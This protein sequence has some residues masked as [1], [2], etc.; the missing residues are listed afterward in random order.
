MRNVLTLPNGST[1]KLEIPS[2]AT[3]T[4]RPNRFHQV[5]YVTAA[6]DGRPV[7]Y[8]LTLDSGAAPQPVLWFEVHLPTPD[9]ASTRRA[10]RVL[11]AAI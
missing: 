10:E 1:R 9:E 3:L 4:P 5:A 7:Y 6:G 2:S 8:I 11:E